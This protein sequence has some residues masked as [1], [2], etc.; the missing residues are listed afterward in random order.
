[1]IQYHVFFDSP[2]QHYIKFKA[3]FP[4]KKSETILNISAWRPGRYELGNFAKN[5][6]N[7]KVF[8]SGGEPIEFQKTDKSSWLIQSG[9]LE[10][11]IVEYEYFAA[12][13]N[14][15]SSFL[16][17]TQLY[18][19][20]VNCFLYSA[21]LKDETYLIILSIPNDWKIACS[22]PFENK[23]LKAKNF[24]ELADS[25]FI[26]SSNL[27][28][29]S[30]EVQGIKFHLWFNNQRQ[31]D[32]NRLKTDFVKFTSKQLADFTHFPA[33]EFHFLIHSLPYSAYHGVE[34][35]KSTVI[36]LG[37]SYEIFGALYSELLGVS[38]HELYHV[39]N[40]KSIRPVEMFPYDF[41]K[42]N[43]SKLGYVYEGVTTYL[44]DLYLLKSGVFNLGSYLKEFNKQLQKHFDNPGRFNYSVS[45]SSFDTWLDGYVAG[46]P[47]R[48]VSIYTEGCLL[49]FIAD[50]KI[51]KATKNQ[52]GIEEVMKRLYFDFAQKGIG[53]SELDY[54]A[55]L[56][57]VSGESFED[58]FSNYIN[59][60]Q[61]YD[62]LIS[63][64]LEYL[65]LE[66]IQQPST[67]FA[68]SKLGFKILPKGKNAIVQSI[69]PKSPSDIGGLSVGDEIIAVNGYQLNYDLDKWLKYFENDDLK[70]SVY[71]EGK[72]LGVPLITRIDFFY[73]KFEVKQ[74]KSLAESQLVNLKFWGQ[75]GI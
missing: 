12:E 67:S 49:A 39:W 20:P 59:G 16:D 63:K 10:E 28:Y 7:F 33:S 37:P 13:L 48:K 31:I 5:V 54:R 44:G 22:L 53:Y 61:P 74:I 1:M 34:H 57:R 65:G 29:D 30:Y 18:V 68:E 73:P 2:N 47:G 72:L 35:L 69:Y 38:S 4:V 21:D 26:C 42:E 58:Y 55:I 32:W 43:Y 75:D 50:I 71:R 41:E 3:V 56:E 64:S 46:A 60:S 62:S 15:G 23:A 24:E 52:F 8:N 19:N 17:E 40:V 45:Q 70:L 66:L 6:R 51:R 11:I 27:S 25:P 9:N 14:A 36:T